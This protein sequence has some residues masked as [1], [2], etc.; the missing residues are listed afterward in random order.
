MDVERYGLRQTHRE[1]G[2]QSSTDI[3]VFV[4]SPRET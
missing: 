3:D 4:H 2:G 1:I